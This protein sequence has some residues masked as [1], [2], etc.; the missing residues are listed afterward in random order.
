MKTSEFG[1]LSRDFENGA[2]ENAGVNSKNMNL[3]EYNR[4]CHAILT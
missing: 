3:S 1:D 4:H 2:R